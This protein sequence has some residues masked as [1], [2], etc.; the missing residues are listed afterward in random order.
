MH[1]NMK[2]NRGAETK[3]SPGRLRNLERWKNCLE[4]RKAGMSYE[5]IREIVGYKSRGS[6]TEALN[7]MIALFAPPAAED[8]ISIE[9]M[10]LDELWQTYYTRAIG[11]DLPSAKFCLEIMALKGK[12]LPDYFTPERFISAAL[13]PTDRLDDAYG[14]ILCL[15]GLNGNGNRAEGAG[16]ST[17]SGAIQKGNGKLPDLFGG[18]SSG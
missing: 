15:L 2:G 14:K 17:P 9:M 10:R 18:G 5:T 11:G 13:S 8:L 7:K 16:G 3:L 4:L 1:R 6:V 12:I